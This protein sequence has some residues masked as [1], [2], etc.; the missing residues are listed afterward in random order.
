MFMIEIDG[1]KGEG[2]GQ[3]L[4]TATALS[5]IAQKPVHVF[6]IRKNRP[7]PGLKT[8][9]LEGIC[10][11][12]DFCGAKLEGA[13]IGSTE[14]KLIPGNEFKKE[15]NIKIPTAGSIGLLFQT[16]KLP[17][18]FAGHPVTVNVEGGGTFNK[19]APPVPYTQNVLLPVLRMMGYNAEI[20]IERHGFYPKGGARAR[21]T[22][23]SCKKL[24]PLRLESFEK[25]KTI[26]GLSLASEHLAKARVAERQKE[27]VIKL[28]GT[29]YDVRI[30]K[31]YAVAS[32]PGSGIVLWSKT[33]GADGLGERG[34]PAETVGKQAVADIVKTIRAKAS[35]DE[36]L[37]DQLIPFM[38]LAEGESAITASSITAHS[39][40]NMWVIKQF[41]DVEFR[42]EKGSSNVTVFC[43]G[44]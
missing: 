39:E 44:K 17:L 22:V 41:L 33:F 9:H 43:S 3:I 34:M 36:H 8:Q 29:A 40:T 14:I 30:K 26:N 24:R 16:L 10:A 7:Q 38:S 37:C 25:P 20:E 12:S 6:N 13:R 42:V 4:R 2:G 27:S 23:Q 18:A 5:V 28:L 19:W 32:S 21:I 15:L 11:L 31:E 35:V 1:S